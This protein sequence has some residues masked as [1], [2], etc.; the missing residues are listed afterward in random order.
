MITVKGHTVQEEFIRQSGLTDIN[1]YPQW[2]RNILQATQEKK[3]QVVHHDVFAMM[4]EGRLPSRAMRNF[5][6]AGWPVI[7]QFPQ[8]MAVNLCKIRYGRSRGEDLARK[9]L[10]HN[11]RVEQNHADHW[12]NWATACGVA[13]AELLTVTAPI[14]SLALSHSCWHTCERDSLAT[15]MAATN[16]AI[17]GATG[18]WSTRVC[19]STVYENTFDQD[20]RHK[21]MRWLN[22]HA[23]YDDTHPWEALDIICTLIGNVAI[24]SYQ[25]LLELRVGQSYDYMTMSLDQCL[26][27]PKK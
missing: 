1:S 22:I 25:S 24:P 3:R 8:Y 26:A 14:E 19:A 6:I 7:E 17:E 18:E 12:V 27:Q 15:S 4:K 13:R 10:L 2:A 23:R 11:I 16:L 9:Y 5:L 20:V 21:A